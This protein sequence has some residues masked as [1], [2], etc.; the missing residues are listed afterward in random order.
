MMLASEFY[1]SKIWIEKTADSYYEYFKD[2]GKIG[3]LG[4]YPKTCIPIEKRQ[5]E[6]RYY[7]FPINPFAMTRQLD[8]LIAYVDNDKVSGTTYCDTIWFDKLLEQM[9]PFEAENRTAFDAV[10]GAMITLCCALEPV[11]VKI[12]V[13]E[14]LV[15]RYPAPSNNN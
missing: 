11:E 7:G 9:L 2:R 6:V 10:V 13:K 12:P 8:S 3:Y 14:P 4:K 1:G 15:K 5:T